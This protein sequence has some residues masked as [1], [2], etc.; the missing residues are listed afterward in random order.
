MPHQYLRLKIGGK[1]MIYQKKEKNQFQKLF[2]IQCFEAART[3][4]QIKTVGDTLKVKLKF[5]L[6]NFYRQ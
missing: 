5:T 2:L 3:I 6:Q 4:V 1:M